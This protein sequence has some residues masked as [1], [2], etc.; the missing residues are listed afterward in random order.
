MLKGGDIMKCR[1]HNNEVLITH[2][3]EGLC[4]KCIVSRELEVD[5]RERLMEKFEL[6]EIDRP[7]IEK[8][9]SSIRE[10]FFSGIRVRC[11]RMYCPIVAGADFIECDHFFPHEYQGKGCDSGVCDLSGEMNECIKEAGQGVK[12]RSGSDIQ[13]YQSQI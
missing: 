13:G 2:E 12:N 1:D 8:L 11:S 7:E 4:G 6:G 9:K 10:I 5:I 3:G